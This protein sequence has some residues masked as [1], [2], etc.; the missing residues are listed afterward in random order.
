MDIETFRSYC[1]AKAGT[2][3][4]FPFDGNTLVIKVGEKMYTAFDVDNFESVNL[5]CDP[6]YALEL[7]TNY[8]GIIPGY[9]MNKKHWNTILMDGSVPDKLVYELIDLSYAL[10]IKGMTKKQREEL[11]LTI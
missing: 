10:V 7:R 5:K 3:E 4:G 1:L 2:T 11:N 8:D 9:H 6:E